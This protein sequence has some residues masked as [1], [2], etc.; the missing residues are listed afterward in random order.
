MEDASSR[1]IPPL[2]VVPVLGDVG[3][4]LERLN[5][6]ENAEETRLTGCGGCGLWLDRPDGE[7]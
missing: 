4:S 6:D 5:E 7:V 1:D 3:V 2:V